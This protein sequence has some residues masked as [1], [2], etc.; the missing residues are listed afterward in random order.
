MGRVR[1]LC[2]RLVILDV[3]AVFATAGRVQELCSRLLAINYPGVAARATKL[4]R[5]RER[6]YRLLPHTVTQ[7]AETVFAFPEC[8][9]AKADSL[10]K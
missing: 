7:F 5:T 6:C 10:H 1:E 3:G 4:R 9:M 2:S 8:R